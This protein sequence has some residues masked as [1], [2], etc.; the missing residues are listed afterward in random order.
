MISQERD[1]A[2][3]E[4]WGRCRSGAGDLHF[5]VSGIVAGTL[6]PNGPAV[7]SFEVGF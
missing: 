3:M 2:R 1:L 6:G 5:A 4:V 7:D